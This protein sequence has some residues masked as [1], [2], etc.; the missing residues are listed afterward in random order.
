MAKQTAASYTWLSVCIQTPL[1]MLRSR[2]D[3]TLQALFRSYLEKAPDTG[4]YI[5]NPVYRNQA[6]LSFM[7]QPSSTR[8]NDQQLSTRTHVPTSAPWLTAS[9]TP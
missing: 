3:I 2:T 8:P 9:E 5:N 6:S 1:N 7:P 4:P